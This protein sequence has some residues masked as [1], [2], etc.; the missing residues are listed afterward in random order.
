MTEHSPM[1]HGPPLATPWSCCAAAIY[2][3]VAVSQV[4]ISLRVTARSWLRTWLRIGC[5]PGG[6]RSGAESAPCAEIFVSTLEVS[7]LQ[8][9]ALDM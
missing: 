2:R 1:Y 4:I 7:A 8:R 5:G 9:S 3:E 6:V